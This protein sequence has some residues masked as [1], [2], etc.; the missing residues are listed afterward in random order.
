MN[1]KEVA[2]GNCM[3]KMYVMLYMRV[4]RLAYGNS[5]CVYLCSANIDF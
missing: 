2:G 4:T 5:I 1:K 3:D